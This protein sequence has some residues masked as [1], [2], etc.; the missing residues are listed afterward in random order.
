MP[1]QVKPMIAE[2]F[3]RLSKQKNI[4]KITVKD[5]VEACGISRQTFYYHS[6]HSGG[7]RVVA[8]SGVFAPARA[9]SRRRRPG[10]RPARLSRDVGGVG[11]AA[12]E[13]P[14]LAKARAG[15]AAPRPLRAHLFKRG[16]RAQRPRA[17]ALVRG[18]G[19]GTQLL[20]IRGRGAA[21]RE[22]REKERR[23]CP[24]R[25]ADAPSARGPHRGG[26]AV[27]RQITAYPRAGNL[28]IYNL[29]H[30][31]GQIR[32]SVK[33]SDTPAFLSGHGGQTDSGKPHRGLL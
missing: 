20:H 17:G 5:L 2:A 24:P 19:H 7:H 30:L 15:R 27:P 9:E 8:G 18:H 21:A 22:L 13:A 14:P 23:P 31:S 25:T 33:N 1:V 29:R 28:P 32:R 26:R 3:I 11:G 16:D 10:G 6:G 4:D 12:A